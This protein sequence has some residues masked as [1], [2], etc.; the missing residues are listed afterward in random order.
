MPE[1]LD[2]PGVKFGFQGWTIEEI[3]LDVMGV[4]TTQSDL[5]TCKMQLFEEFSNASDKSNLQ[6]ILDELS[7]MLHP[8]NP[9]CKL[10][11]LQAADVL[12]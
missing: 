9:M 1:V 6:L 5:L 11:R 8:K 12:G 4:K 3:L 7:T 2:P 10:L